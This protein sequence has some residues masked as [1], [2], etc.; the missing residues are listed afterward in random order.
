MVLKIKHFN[1]KT[2]EWI[3]KEPGQPWV[4][5]LENT[6]L[7][8]LFPGQEFSFAQVDESITA[9]ELRRNHPDGERL[10]FSSKTRFLYGNEEVLQKVE[11]MFP[12]RKDRGAYGSLFL[13]SCLNQW[14]KQLNILIVDDETG[15]SGGVLERQTAWELVGDCHGKIRGDLAGELAGT[16]KHVIQHRF[17]LTGK[18]PVR[19]GKGT[20]APMDL[21]SRWKGI[22]LVLP[23]SSF[24]GG[25]QINFPL[26]PGLYCQ[27]EIWIGAKELSQQGKM[28][29]AQIWSSYPEGLKDVLPVVEVEAQK[30]AE[31]Q[32]DPR[33][34]AED[35]VKQ[36]SR[37]LQK[38]LEDPD[39]PGEVYEP[40]VYKILKT[41]L[42][43]ENPSWD[44]LEDPSVVRELQNF[45]KKRWLD[46]ALGRAI[47]FDRGMIVPSK[48]LKDGEICVPWYPQGQ[49]VLS[50]RSPF[51]TA[52][53]MAMGVNRLDLPEAYGVDG[54]PL[55]GVIVVSEETLAQLQARKPEAIETECMEMGRDFDGDYLAV[56]L[57]EDYP[58]LRA[59]VQ[60]RKLPENRYQAIPKLEKVSFYRDDGSQPEF[61][62][63]ALHMSDR[64]SVG[65]INNS[66]SAI[67]A[68]ESEIALAKFYGTLEEQVELY[69]RTVNHFQ[70][71]ERQKNGIPSQHFQQVD[72]II[73]RYER[74][75]KLDARE[76][77]YQPELLK[78]LTSLQS[79]YKRL[80]YEAGKENQ[81]AVDIFKS[82][83][84]PNIEL[85]K[86]NDKLLYRKPSFFSEKKNHHIYTKEPL[87]IQGYSPVEVMINL[88]NKY[89]SASSLQSRPNIQFQDLFPQ[90]SFSELVY[91]TVKNH[92]IQ[93]DAL[94]NRATEQKIKLNSETGYVIRVSLG[95][96]KT[97]ELTNCVKYGSPRI[98][99]IQGQEII[100][101]ENKSNSTPHQ[102]IALLKTPKGY[103]PL[104]T[105]SETS[106]QN[107]GLKAQEQLL[108]VEARY[109]ANLSANQIKALFEEAREF[110]QSLKQGK[111]PAEIRELAAAA[112]QI[113]YASKEVGVSNKFVWVAFAEEIL[114]YLAD[115]HLQAFGVN[116]V[117]TYGQ[118][119]PSAL[120][121]KP[122]SLLVD[123]YQDRDKFGQSQFLKGWYLDSLD[124]RNASERIYLG[125]LNQSKAQLPLATKVEGK[126][127]PGLSHTATLSLDGEPI[128][129]GNIQ[130]YSLRQE[131]WNNTPV[132]VKIE[133]V[134]SYAPVVSIGETKLGNLQQKSLAILKDLE[135]I[136]SDNTLKKKI[137]LAG[138]LTTIKSSNS[139]Y[140]SV[141]LATEEI[142][143]A[144]G[145]NLVLQFNNQV[146]GRE[147]KGERRK[148]T[149]DVEATEVIGI[150]LSKE[151]EQDYILAGELTNSAESRKGFNVLA[152][153]NLVKNNSV[154]T[155]TVSSNCSVG[156]IIP[157]H[158]TLPPIGQWYPRQEENQLLTNW[159][160]SLE[161]MTQKITHLP[162]F[163]KQERIDGQERI[164]ICLDSRQAE[165]LHQFL[166][167]RSI[168]FE[169]FKDEESDNPENQLGLTVF[170]VDL[171]DLNPPSLARLY[172]QFNCQ[173]LDDDL[174]DLSQP[175][176]YQQFFKSLK[177]NQL[178]LAAK[179]HISS[180][181][182]TIQPLLIFDAATEEYQLSFDRKKERAV[183]AW[184]KRDLGC[185][186]RNLTTAEE[187]KIGLIRYALDFPQV[188]L[189]KF[190]AATL[191]KTDAALTP[192]Q[193]QQRLGELATKKISPSL[194]D[195]SQEFL[196]ST[197]AE[198]RQQKTA[199]AAQKM[200]PIA[201]KTAQNFQSSPIPQQENSS[202]SDG[203]TRSKQKNSSNSHPQK[204]PDLSKSR[205]F[206]LSS[207]PSLTPKYQEVLHMQEQVNKI[208]H[209]LYAYTTLKS[210]EKSNTFDSNT[211]I[212]CFDLQENLLTFTHKE[213]REVRLAA[214]F[215][216]N[217]QLWLAQPELV[218]SP[219]PE[220]VVESVLNSEASLVEQLLF[221]KALEQP[222]RP[223]SP[224]S[225]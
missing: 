84:K 54:R 70:L 173:V 90:D 215:D 7:E 120:V 55:S 121:D 60:R 147:F 71:L 68:L 119:H 118:M 126:F 214:K 170:R 106:R 146:A 192:E 171:T 13:G 43:K 37:N 74:W 167:Y 217:S 156:E 202:T 105:V 179:P 225:R 222:V 34:L 11:Q 133:R 97:L 36:T 177:P 80:I 218:D 19:V 33:L 111:S 66:L 159:E 165:N 160:R 204:T 183:F 211:Y 79:L 2:K 212:A 9:E 116:G 101:A 52:N 182:D 163:A 17:A 25:D 91:N 26:Q 220:A 189:E 140:N 87:R 130:K 24:K 180:L 48:H 81:V 29:T 12:N 57:A 98:E 128:T 109:S 45:T 56:A 46:L 115:H 219:L 203:Q 186:P 102:L 188:T 41:D 206:Q 77:N 172:E 213:S 53:G 154:F 137:S 205:N 51:L 5:N 129:F 16:S 122:L 209:I 139:K 49:E 31:L 175:T 138:S 185:E 40:V 61:E 143:T 162:T 14:K 104:G 153:R 62:E 201:G 21:E 134:K 107:L 184:L 100:L 94:F 3:A 151:G 88:V 141:I 76:E 73:E 67:E 145:K 125:A 150:H 1:L 59:E 191:K 157:T 72:A 30:L 85:V 35:Y 168:P 127:V 142:K 149:I 158:I 10:L 75:E 112:W 176:A 117:G 23:L 193:Y 108:V 8:A 27:Q 152:K 93:F 136:N 113:C 89:F 208:A 164:K 4:E 103:Q 20:L 83:V 181:K 42:E 148:I 6:L 207:P 190:L 174:N 47:T 144:S 187:E 44:L 65:I 50:F 38:K 78:G 210:N 195:S 92:K 86:N 161:A 15:E 99:L 64:I 69:S 110:A 22:D 114:E 123:N 197:R 63:I 224:L 96:D 223:V 18:T 200:A 32:Q 221:E 216:A 178:A 135:L 82:N 196:H 28:A 199:S 155:A 198:T 124:A 166:S 131:Y 39:Y 132:S 58:H 194:R 95:K 169:A